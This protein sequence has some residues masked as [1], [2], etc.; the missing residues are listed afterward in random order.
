[1]ACHQLQ[2]YERVGVSVGLVWGLYELFGLLWKER[3]VE[4]LLKA[5]AFHCKSMALD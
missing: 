2:G 3:E 5:V 4:T 1:M